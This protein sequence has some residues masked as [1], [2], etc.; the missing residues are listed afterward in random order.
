MNF[1]LIFK[2]NHLYKLGVRK[3]EKGETNNHFKLTNVG[4]DNAIFQ[5]RSRK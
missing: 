3:I 4:E 1:S 5:N 2:K